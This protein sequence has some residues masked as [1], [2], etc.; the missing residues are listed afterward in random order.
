MHF[1]SDIWQETKNKAPLVLGLTA[2]NWTYFGLIHGTIFDM[3]DFL[4]IHTGVVTI[5]YLTSLSMGSKIDN[6][7]FVGSSVAVLESFMLQGTPV[8]DT[9]MTAFL[10]TFVTYY[11]TNNNN[12]NLL[13]NNMNY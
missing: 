13:N 5:P 4:A 7:I 9:I 6:P 10:N 1:I 8:T 12:N 2:L 11:M 3:Y